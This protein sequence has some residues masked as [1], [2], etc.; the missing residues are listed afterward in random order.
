MGSENGMPISIISD[1]A[2]GNFCIILSEVSTSGS[3][4]VT[5]VTRPGRPS[6]L[7]A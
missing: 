7:K 4:A 6:L 3:P 2:A 1:P 5:K